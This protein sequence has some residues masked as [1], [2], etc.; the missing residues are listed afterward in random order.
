MPSIIRAFQLVSTLSSRPGRMRFSRAAK[1][2]SRARKEQGDVR[3]SSG[4]AILGVPVAI[5]EVRRAVE[6][7]APSRQRRLL[8]RQQMLDFGAIPDVVLAFLA[9]RV[10]I[11]RGVIAA[12][13]RLHFAHH[14]G[15][16]FF[17]DAGEQG[18]AA[19]RPGVGAER[20]QRPVVVE[21]FFEVG[22]FPALVDAVA[23][24][25]AA[26]LVVDAAF[27]HARQ[28]G[29]RHLARIRILRAAGR[30]GRSD[31]ETS[32]HRRSRRGGCRNREPA[33]CGGGQGRGVE[34]GSRCRGFGHGIGQRL[35][36]FGG[37]GGD[38]RAAVAVG[39]RDALAEIGKAGQA[40]ARFFG[41]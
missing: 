37:L 38:V 16:G 1:S 27:A 25:A 18:V 14:P 23:A 13:G 4:P 29:Q 20:Q 28:R 6:A 34:G 3:E 8:R 39:F 32:A 15:R 5:L 10:G 22:N 26:D 7:P 21:H 36:Q 9:L 11:E 17:G 19:L 41:K 2:F 33:A 40:V 31:A 12:V 30:R 24:E 35:A